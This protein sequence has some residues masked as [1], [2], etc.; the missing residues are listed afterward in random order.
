MS[1]YETDTDV[2]ALFE[3]FENRTLPKKNWTHAAHLTVGLVYCL[4]HSFGKAKNL[5]RDGIYRLNDSH[6]TLNSETSGYHETLTCFWM[7]TIREFLAKCDRNKGVAV[8]ANELVEACHDAK[9]PLRFYSREL[10]F[11]PAAR[12]NFVGPDLKTDF[13]FSELF[14]QNFSPEIFA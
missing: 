6:G 13:S 8:L 11:S 14:Y 10:L 1:L 3:A 9:L 5:M 4:N 7:E 12:I 2:L